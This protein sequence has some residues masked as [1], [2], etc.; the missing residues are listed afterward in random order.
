MS[1]NGNGGGWLRGHVPDWARIAGQLGVVAV[2]ML[3]LSYILHDNAQQSALD[4]AVMRDEIRLLRQAVADQ[5]VSTRDAARA[6][7]D[8]AVQTRDLI[9]ALEQRRYIP[10]PEDA[11]Q[12]EKLPKKE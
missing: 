3:L 6:V 8:Q 7:A 11:P 4:R 2:G 5:A 12:G 9:R 1:S 10:P